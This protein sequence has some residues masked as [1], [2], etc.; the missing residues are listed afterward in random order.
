MC[1]KKN[2][3]VTESHFLCLLCTYESVVANN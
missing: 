1:E 3:V 2:A